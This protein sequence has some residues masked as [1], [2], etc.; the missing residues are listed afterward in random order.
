[1]TSPYQVLG[2]TEHVTDAEIKQA[3]L[4]RVKENPP[5]RDQKRFQQIQRAYETIKDADSRLRHTLFDLPEIEFNALLDQAFKPTE[6]FKPLSSDDFCK[7]LDG[8]LVEKALANTL[9]AHHHDD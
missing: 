7:L 5:D 2:V 8:T 1:M 9:K 3:Y 4:Q 6:K